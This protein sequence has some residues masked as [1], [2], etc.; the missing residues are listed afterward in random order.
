METFVRTGLENIPTILN[1][2]NSLTVGEKFRF[3]AKHKDLA[4]KWFPATASKCDNF[5]EI[6]YDD[7]NLGTQNIYFD[8]EKE[9]LVSENLWSMG[10]FGIL[11]EEQNTA[12]ISDRTV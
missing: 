7:P 10:W 12:L 6:K 1:Q 8:D 9:L 5:F 11:Q 3:A 4:G 2:L